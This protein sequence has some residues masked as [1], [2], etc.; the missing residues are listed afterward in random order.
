MHKLQ[1]SYKKILEAIQEGIWVYDA[2]SNITF[3]N[4]KMAE[5][6]GYEKEEMIGK[7]IFDFFNEEV[8]KNVEKRVERR[9]SGISETYEEKLKHKDGHEV[10]VEI[11]VT[12]I[13][14]DE[15]N[16][17]GG[18]A[19]FT[20]IYDRKQAEENLKTITDN[21]TDMVSKTD[22]K[23][24]FV[25]LAESSHRVLG[26]EPRELIGRSVFELVHQEDLPYIMER[27]QKAIATGSSDRV[28]YRIKKKDGNYLWV[29]TIGNFI[30]END[31]VIGAVFNTRDI[32]KRKVAEESL[33]KTQ[34][35]VDKSPLSIFWISPEGKFIYVNETATK[36]LGYSQDE[37]LS[38]HV[39]DVDPNYPQ[40][41]RK[42]QWNL[43]RQE[44]ERSVESEHRRRDGTT[45]PV[46]ININHLAFE[47]Q[48]MEVAE[49]EDI[50]E[51]KQAEEALKLQASERAAVDTFTYSVSNDLQA[52]LRR[53]EGF[54]NAL[55]E[56][57]PEQLNDQ[58]RNYL[59]RIVKQIDSMK[60]INLALLKLSRVVSHEI[61]KEAIDLSTLFRS[62]LKKL[63]LQEPERQVETVVAPQLTVEGDAELLKILLDNLLDNAWKFTSGVE[64]ALIELGSTEQ[65]GQTVYYL[66]DN[67]VGFDMNHADKLFVPFQKLHSDHDYPG[68]GVGLNLVYRIISRHG[69]EIWAESE[70]G[71]G[72]CFCFTLP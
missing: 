56:E 2:D 61:N 4:P 60:K 25:Y 27:F 33:R 35:T 23:G 64:D 65:D 38:M 26:Y 10:Y 21:M 52:P 22:A 71:K 3:V 9:K 46:R 12:P 57:C 49:A 72:A 17:N 34:L 58:A 19:G 69:G 39:W 6:S 36:K 48:E 30:S 18:I 67:G 13:I 8:I 54:S 50:T 37:L 68:I 62:Y 42:E 24:N 59:N 44:K 51:S 7:P 11:K 29:E 47:G 70:P 20:N 45:F 14:N 63:Q 55:L 41:K 15:G 1:I 40:E 32:S 5:I 66:K 31:K 53:I 16:F 43:H 28:E